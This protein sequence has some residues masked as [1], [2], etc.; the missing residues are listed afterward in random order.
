MMARSNG[1]HRH[2]DEREEDYIFTTLERLLPDFE[3]DVNGWS[4]P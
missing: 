4:A 3:R 2:L 1:D